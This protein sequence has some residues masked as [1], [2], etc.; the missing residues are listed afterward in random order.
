VFFFKN[1]T[2]LSGRDLQGLYGLD[3]SNTGIVGSNPARGMDVYP[4]FSA[5]CCPIESL[6]WADPLPSGPIKM[7]KRIHSFRS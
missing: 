5:L 2:Y 6:R 7:S 4:R 1:V 3:R